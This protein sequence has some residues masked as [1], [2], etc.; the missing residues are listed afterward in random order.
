MIR[1]FKPKY[2]KISILIGCVI[3]AYY[4]FSLAPVKTFV[5]TLGFAGY[6]G[7]F[8][9]GLLFSFGFTTPFAIGALVVMNPTNPLLYAIIG[10]LGAMISDLTIFK[11]VKVSF[12]NEFKALMKTKTA[13]R[14]SYVSPTFNK[15]VKHYLLYAFAGIIIASPLPDELG[16]TMLAGLSHIKAFPLAVISFI[17]NT[18]GILLMLLI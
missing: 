8:I 7:V 12:L 1:L 17:F 9:A 10:G 2:P 6:L 3:L 5:S 4:I 16:V 18:L 13:I 14:L 15:K 11:I